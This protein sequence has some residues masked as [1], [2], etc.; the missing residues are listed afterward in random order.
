[1]FARSIT[2]TPARGNT[3]LNPDMMKQA[4]VEKIIALIKSEVVPAIGCTEPIAV[5]LAV[6]KAK[7]LLPE[8]PV[9][10]EVLLS[11]NILK[12]SYGVGI[13]GTG[14]IGLPIAVA[15]GMVIGKPEYGLEVLKD[16]NPEG[17]EKAKAIVSADNISIK[18]KKDVPDKLYI[19]AYCY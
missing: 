12:N 3:F 6:S 15:L 1:M 11:A 17:L 8:P 4:E 14:M 7:E 9:R 16:L 2:E 19:E 10:S 18:L 5:A 13:P